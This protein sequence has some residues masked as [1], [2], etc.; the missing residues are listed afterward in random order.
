MAT[1]WTQVQDGP[2]LSTDSRASGVGKGTNR[3]SHPRR[4][5]TCRRD[6]RPCGRGDRS[7][8]HARAGGWTTD[9]S[10][11]GGGRSGRPRG[12]DAHP[13]AGHRRRRPPHR[14]AGRTAGGR[15]RAPPGPAGNPLFRGR[16]RRRRP[17]GPDRGDAVPE[18]RPA[19]RAAVQPHRP[20]GGGL[21]R[22]GHR[23]PA[24]PVRAD[25]RRSHHAQGTRV[26]P[27]PAQPRQRRCP[28]RDT[29][30]S[31]GTDVLGVDRRRHPVR[32][33]SEAVA[34]HRQGLAGRP[35]QDHPRGERSADRGTRRVAGGLHRQGREGRRT[36]HRLR[37]GTPRPGRPGGRVDVVRS[38]RD[39]PGRHGPRHPRRVDRRWFGRRLAVPPPRRRTRCRPA[40]RQGARQQRQRP[41]VVDH[42]GDGM[43]RGQRREGREHEPGRSC[44]QR[45]RPDERRGGRTQCPV[46]RA[47]RGG[48]RQRRTR[49]RQR[50]YAGHG[51]LGPDG[52]RG[53]QG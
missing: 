25:D 49:E 13:H 8:G 43:G 46:G 48:R 1:V 6:P 5:R 7:G 35:G 51:F 45:N 16:L 14:A 42:R 41:G 3:A 32:R 11:R 18:Q 29:A 23:A 2:K 24:D 4:R 40:R 36:R 17:V 15:S 44:H 20:R 26:G 31:R 34:W 52:G 21:R 19:G 9:G 12:E 28:C 27:A 33:S 22:R 10:H 39:R 53:H 38:R 37:R 47:L 50:R 30:R